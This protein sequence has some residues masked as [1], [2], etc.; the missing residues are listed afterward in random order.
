MQLINYS[1]DRF[2]WKEAM[3]V[4]KTVNRRIAHLLELL[5]TGDSS[6]RATLAHLR[7]GVNLSPGS[8]PEIWEITQFESVVDEECLPNSPTAAE[9]ATHSALCIFA[10]HQQGQSAEMH[11]EG[12][13][14]VSRVAELVIESGQDE[15]GT[16][17]RRL[18]S[19]LTARSIDKV[20]YEV[21]GLIILL[22]NESF[23]I[24]YGSLAQ[25]IFEY[26]LPFRADRIRLKW[27]REYAKQIAI[28]EEKLMKE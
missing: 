18:N 19:A 24:D 3:L 12:S 15:T 27:A 10:W 13:D 26:Q 23:A 20:L 28:L 21:R 17:R 7:R 1:E 8:S 25:D 5:E 9:I 2:W 4:K 14:F 16:I 11:I 6:A 22:R